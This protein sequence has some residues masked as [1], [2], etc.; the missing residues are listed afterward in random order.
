MC[1][2][3]RVCVCVCVC[4]VCRSLHGGVRKKEDCMRALQDFCMKACVC[5][6]VMKLNHSVSFNQLNLFM[7][8]HALCRKTR[9]RLFRR[10]RLFILSRLLHILHKHAGL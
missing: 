6:L 1:V 3:V 2:C 8:M 4:E 7:H 9:S 5:I 10:S